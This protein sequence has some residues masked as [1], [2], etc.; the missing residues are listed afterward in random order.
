[1]S[2]D[3]Y[4]RKVNKNAMY[5]CS[6]GINSSNGDNSYIFEEIADLKKKIKNIEDDGDSDD[7]D[8]IKDLANAY[9]YM[10]EA[11]EEMRSKIDK[12]EK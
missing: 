8:S 12:L 7:I 2:E 1:M 11:L 9:Q 10:L 6:I 5:P 4:A 3:R